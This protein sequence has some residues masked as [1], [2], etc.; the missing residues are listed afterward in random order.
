[1]SFGRGAGPT[2]DGG[3]EGG[4]ELEGGEDEASCSSYSGSSMNRMQPS[5]ASLND[6]MEFDGMDRGLSVLVVCCTLTQP[7]ERK[8]RTLNV[9]DYG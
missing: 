3:N 6:G 7:E 9:G 5:A 4:G 8:R 1:M 2:G